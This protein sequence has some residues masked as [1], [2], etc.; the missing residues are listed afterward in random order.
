M[1]SNT[2]LVDYNQEILVGYLKLTKLLVDVL[3]IVIFFVDCTNKCLY[4]F[5]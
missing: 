1:K 4:D 3:L 2:Y 5:I